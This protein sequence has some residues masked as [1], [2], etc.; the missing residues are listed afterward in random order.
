M[1]LKRAALSGLAVPLDPQ[2]FHSCGE[3]GGLE[4]EDAGGALGSADAPAGLLK[5]GYDVLPL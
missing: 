2:L 4:A 3:G 1:L 5:D